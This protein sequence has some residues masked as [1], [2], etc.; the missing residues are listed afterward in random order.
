MDREKSALMLGHSGAESVHAS[1]RRWASQNKIGLVESCVH[2]A[3]RAAS[4]VAALSYFNIHGR[5]GKGPSLFELRLRD[6]TAVGLV[7]SFCTKLNSVLTQPDMCKYS[8]VEPLSEDV[9]TV[10]MKR[11]AKIPR[12]PHVVV[13]ESHRPDILMVTRPKK[14]KFK[15]IANRDPEVVNLSSD[16]SEE[17]DTVVMEPPARMTR[18]NPSS[19]PRTTRLTPRTPR[20]PARVE[21]NFSGGVHESDGRPGML[22]LSQIGRH[23]RSPGCRGRK[24]GKLI[25]EVGFRHSDKGVVGVCWLGDSKFA[26][27]GVP[28]AYWFC[29]NNKC[30]L[31][32]CMSATITG[33]LPPLPQKFPVSR[34]TSLSE[35]EVRF[36]QESGVEVA[37][38]D[39]RQ[40]DARCPDD[41]QVGA[42]DTILDL[43]KFPENVNPLRPDDRLLRRNSIRR[44]RRSDTTKD[45]KARI[46]TAKTESMVCSSIQ[47]IETGNATGLRVFVNNISR[48]VSSFHCVQICV[49]PAC[50]C[51]DFMYRESHPKTWFPCKH[52]Y[53]CFANICKKNLDTDE[54]VHQPILTLNEVRD[55]VSSASLH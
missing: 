17:S 12:G 44:R 25:R 30:C 38:A 46:C 33:P 2:D 42:G 6:S 53:W 51:A 8:S 54:V 26:D 52:M 4:Q 37:S 32:C 20:R 13:E 47:R 34:G 14:R 24:C 36:L 29:P 49:F 45:A 35:D 5:R 50:S 27:K 7:Q 1:M 19:A 9:E 31:K 15:G 16:A 10:P 48:G 28:Y 18:S 21:R 39:T 40:V 22:F 3:T 55:L 23:G 41:I 11:G 43:E